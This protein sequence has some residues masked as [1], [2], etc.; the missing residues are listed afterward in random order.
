MQI[1]QDFIFSIL[2][3]KKDFRRFGDYKQY[4]LMHS[5]NGR[6]TNESSD[7]QTLMTICFMFSKS[8]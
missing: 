7:T 5:W 8:H 2:Y 6:T 3:V 4:S 1:Y